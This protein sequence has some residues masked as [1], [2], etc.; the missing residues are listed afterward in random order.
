MSAIMGVT[1]LGIGFGE[2]VEWLVIAGV[3]SIVVY[4]ISNVLPDRR[5]RDWLQRMVIWGF[6][7]KLVGSFLRYY[8]AIDL[9][10]TGD[11]FRYHSRGA[12]FASIWRSL[13]I[14]MSDAGGQGTA[15]TE[16][17]TGLVYS[18]YTPTLRGGFLMFAF[19]SFLGQLLFYAAFRP[20]LKDKA[21]KRYAIAILFF[22]SL[23][24]WPSSIGKDALMTLF[25][26]LATFGISRLLK[27]FEVMGLITAGLGLYLAAQVRPHVAIMLALA[28][29]LAFLLMRRGPAT[30]GGVK[31]LVLLAVA[32]VGLTFAWGAFAT[33]FGVSL[34]GGGDTA[35]P[36]AFLERVQTQT[37]QGGSEVTGG[38]VNSPLDLPE[39]TLKVL[40]RPLINETTNIA[41]LVSALEGTAL[42]LLVV[43]KSPM[44][45]RNR[46]MVR[47]NP[48][49]LLSFFYT[50][51]FIIA[52]SS[53]LN[54]GILARQR[55]QVL[56]YLLA[57]LITL[58][59]PDEESEEG[60]RGQRRVRPPAQAPN[61]IEPAGGARAH[62]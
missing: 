53:I 43:W 61:V 46:R 55:V 35:D 23:V 48:L 42:L 47:G 33:D 20:W 4:W 25:L 60:V 3:L 58:G 34:E 62:R 49:L 29:A 7:A 41:T 38:I 56:P 39:A 44:M 37:A 54:L 50:G 59:W 21:L 52:F 17:V 15:F 40:F 19:L 13:S 30:T 16:V 18:I 11:A 10:G 6:T 27:R 2:I 14:P 24:F 26:G 22:P 28:G 1:V 31:R 5:D 51:G 8:M 12:A 45:F 32:V 36:G 9:Y 57:L